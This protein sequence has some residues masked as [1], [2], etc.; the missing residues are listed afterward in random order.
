MVRITPRL[1]MMVAISCLTLA[2]HATEFENPVAFAPG[3]NA[4]TIKG[5]VARGDR[6]IYL[7][8]A[9]AGQ[10]MTV[11]LSALEHNAAFSVFAPKAKIPVAGTEEENSLTA[12]NGTLPRSGEYRIVVGGTRGNAS[13]RL[14]IR[15]E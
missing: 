3:K 2:V 6:D 10:Q 11:Q 12:W 9:R 8:R 7:L 4:A 14:Q 15:I 5:D 1:L 13:Y